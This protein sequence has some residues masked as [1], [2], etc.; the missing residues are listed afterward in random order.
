M[1]IAETERLWLRKLDVKDAES[2]FALN[3]DPDVMQYT[4]DVAFEN[5]ESAKQFLENYDHYKQYGFGRW[6]VILKTD[7]SFLG[8]CGLKYTPS[9]NEYDIGFRFFKRYWNQGY[10]TEAAN[11]CIELGFEQY[12]M[13][14]I[15]G[16]V[17]EANMASIKVLKKIGLEYEGKYN[18]DG[19]AGAK[20]I[21]KK[22]NRSHSPPKQFIPPNSIYE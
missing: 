21:I 10:A 20:Y 2:F 7:S 8:W 6:A 9:L 5:V 19:K 18:F 11:K 1:Y 14:T 4:G 15:I 3:N 12:K 13:E 17:M 22:S 16:R